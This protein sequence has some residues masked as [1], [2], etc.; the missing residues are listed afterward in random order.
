MNSYEEMIGSIN[1]LYYDKTTSIPPDSLVYENV[2]NI[3]WNNKLA[4]QRVY[5]VSKLLNRGPD[6][7]GKRP[8]QS[9]IWYNPETKVGKGHYH[10]FEIHDQAYQHS[11][12]ARHADFFFVWLRMKMKPEKATNI[13]K[14]TTSAFYYDP[15]QLVCAACHFIEASI[16]T[17]SVL[18]D[19]NDDKINL[20]QAR[21]VYDNRIGELL[22]E[23]LKSEQNEDIRNYPT[24]LRDILETY[25]VSDMV[26]DEVFQ[27]YSEAKDVLVIT[28][29]TIEEKISPPRTPI[30][31]MADMISREPSGL[32]PFE[33]PIPV[34]SEPAIP[35][36]S[37]PP[38]PV[39]SEPLSAVSPIS[40]M[41]ETEIIR[42][43]TMNR[44]E[45]ELRSRGVDPEKLINGSGVPEAITNTSSSDLSLVAGTNGNLGSL[46]PLSQLGSGVGAI[47]SIP[48]SSTPVS[49][50][51][52]IPR[53]STEIPSGS[54]PP[55]PP[56][57]IRTHG[58]QSMRQ[59][60]LQ[61]VQTNQSMAVLP[62]V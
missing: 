2:W 26:P 58:S 44:L 45:S 34:S 28:V 18:K 53:V 23:F 20:E 3:E 35:V 4:I 10:K 16:A 55:R 52:S 27:G 62:G 13:N 57:S 50:I 14:I 22:E 32:P 31:S 41:T 33:P 24:P 38:I 37:E 1:K 61:S 25:I 46:P 15:G 48:V 60:P 51:R 9:A 47:S 59:L 54:A 29:E 30:T 5:E 8:G 42:E 19:Y 6:V 7:L 49:T 21:Q 40:S 17:F 12:P 11:K 43:L 36:S 39:S 56:M